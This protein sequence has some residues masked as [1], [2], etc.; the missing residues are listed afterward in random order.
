MKYGKLKIVDPN[1]QQFYN[2][3]LDSLHKSVV[4]EE[5][6]D[7]FKGSMTKKTSAQALESPFLQ[8]LQDKVWLK[9][10]IHMKHLIFRG[11]SHFHMGIDQFIWTWSRRTY[12]I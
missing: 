3:V 2:V 5:M 1:V 8:S 9:R 6:E 7:I 11:A 10:D 12:N 4:N